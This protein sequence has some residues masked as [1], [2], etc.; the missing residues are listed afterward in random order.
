[1]KI[2]GSHTENT[3]NTN[4]IEHQQT[5]EYREKIARGLIGWNLNVIVMFNL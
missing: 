4:E 2:I 1:M 5:K 3:S